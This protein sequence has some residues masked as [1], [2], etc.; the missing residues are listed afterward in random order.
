MPLSS[1]VPNAKVS[2]TNMLI[3]SLKRLKKVGISLPYLITDMGYLDGQ[4]KIIA[5]KDFSTAVITEV[6]KNMNVPETCDQ[7]GRVQCP[8]EHLAVYDGFDKE[9]LTVTYCG[10]LTKRRSCLRYG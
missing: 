5:M 3:P 6:K 1:V 9:T 4:N 8:E 7:K 10:D 2:N